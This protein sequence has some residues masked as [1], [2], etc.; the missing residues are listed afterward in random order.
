MCAS[1]RG[2]GSQNQRIAED[3]AA[4]DDEIARNPV[5]R[6][7]ERN[8]DHHLRHT[9]HDAHAMTTAAINAALVYG[10]LAP[11]GRGEEYMYMEESDGPLGS[12]DDMFSDGNISHTLTM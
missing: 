11:Q 7:L 12:D 4:H 2:C 8:Y 5:A 1:T 3:A 6:T 9:R 10:H